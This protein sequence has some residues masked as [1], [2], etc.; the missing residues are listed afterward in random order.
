M[1]V[2]FEE[3]DFSQKRYNSVQ[4]TGGMANWLI[5]HNLAKDEASANKILIIVTILCFVLSAYFVFFR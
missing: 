2:E 1:S 5:K 3:D 4:R